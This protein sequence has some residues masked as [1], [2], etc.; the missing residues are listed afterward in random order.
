[1][2]KYPVKEGRFP[3]VSG[4][5]FGFDPEAPSGQRVAHDLVKVQGKYL[6]LEKVSLDL[7]V[8]D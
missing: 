3:Q 5:E 1:M 6:N 7:F 8:L 4:V 2:S